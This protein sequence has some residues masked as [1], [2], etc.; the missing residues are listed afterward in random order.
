MTMILQNVNFGKNL[1][2]LRKNSGLSQYELTAK[3]QL[4]GSNMSRSTYAKIELGERNIKVTDMILLKKIFDIE[5]DEFFVN[6]L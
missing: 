3:M 2:R 5:F 4:M 1:L 6:I